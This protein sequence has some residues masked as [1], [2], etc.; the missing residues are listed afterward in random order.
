MERNDLN[1][2][3]WLK[4]HGD[5]KVAILVIKDNEDKKSVRVKSQSKTK[6][7]VNRTFKRSKIKKLCTELG[8]EVKIGS[9][10]TVTVKELLEA[11]EKT[12]KKLEKKA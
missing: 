8:I 3:A 12:L 9:M 4:E 5:T 11:S 7:F 6:K 10:Q 1:L 2:A